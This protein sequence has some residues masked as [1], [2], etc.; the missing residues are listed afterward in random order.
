MR[1]V[2]PTSGVRRTRV[3]G[4]SCALEDLSI[5]LIGNGGRLWNVVSENRVCQIR[6]ALGATPASPGV[7]KSL[8]L[9]GFLEA[10]L[11]WR[12]GRIPTPDTLE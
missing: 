6:A 1:P 12:R 11:M 4:V 10:I 7:Q 3:G 5:A 2:R 9:W 8:I